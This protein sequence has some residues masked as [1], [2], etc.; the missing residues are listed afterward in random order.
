[1]RQLTRNVSLCLAIA[2]IPA[3]PIAD[4]QSSETIPVE[5]E[6]IGDRVVVAR[7]PVGSNVTAIN[8]TRGVV[9]VDTHLSPG[10]MRAIRAKI[11]TVFGQS[12][13]PYVINTHGH[14]DHC[15][16]NQVF[17]EAS[18]VGHASSPV[19]MRNH[20]ADSFGTIW[21]QESRLSRDRQ[22]LE[23]TDHPDKSVELR[24]KIRAREQIVSDLRTDY[25]SMPP[26]VTVRDRWDLDLGDV[27]IQLFYCGPAHSI[28]DIFVYLPGERILMT[29]DVFCSPTSFC[30]TVN[31]LI[32]VPRLLE[33]LDYVLG[34]GVDTV[35]P[36]HDG[37]MSGED[38]RGLRERLSE[39][40]AGQAG[41]VS[42]AL[43][44]EQVIEADG[45]EQ[46]ELLFRDI[47]WDTS[48]AG[49][50]SEDELCLLGNRFIDKSQVAAAEMVFELTGELF[51]ESASAYLGR[52]KTSLIRGD[53]LSAIS[54]Y[55]RAY[56]LA[57]YH[58]QLSALIQR[59]RGDR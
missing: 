3:S 18:I 36:G 53:T 11:E 28:T 5:I 16:G 2:P 39:E 56:E 12:R 34:Q 40:L 30:F 25:V 8:T 13:I 4:W 1:M 37:L 22:E 32:D 38:L 24:A 55:E 49:Y 52:G 9:I 35:V 31:P 51:P 57:P 58:R 14:W 47:T 19:F 29:G 43:T 23:S 50:L 10:M 26:T 21:S 46:A 42:A 17:P 41:V 6:R 48:A 20:R 45:I 44:L 59:L 27:P 33:V 15:S 54:A 7:C